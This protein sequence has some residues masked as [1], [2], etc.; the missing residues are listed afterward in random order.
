MFSLYLALISILPVLSKVV[1]KAMNCPISNISRG[2]NSST[3]SIMVFYKRGPL[4]F[5]F[6]CYLF[7]AQT[8]CTPRAVGGQSI[9]IVTVADLKAQYYLP[10]RL[11]SALMT[12]FPPLDIFS[13]NSE[14]F[15]TSSRIL[16][17][18]LDH[19]T[20]SVFASKQMF[21]LRV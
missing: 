12:F 17:E 4:R 21:P 11:F 1:E 18:R 9:A 2:T 15:S 5:P 3:T 8:F 16:I 20:I 14:R 6:L 19:V 7:M 10:H 13:T